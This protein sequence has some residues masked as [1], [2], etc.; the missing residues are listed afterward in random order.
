MSI[1]IDQTIQ[2]VITQLKTTTD[3]EVIKAIVTNAWTKLKKV[4]P[5]ESSFL[6]RV[7][8]PLR[9]AIA[10]AFPERNIEEQ[11]V[12]GYY[13]TNAGKNKEGRWEHLG[14]WYATT[15]EDRWNITGDAARAE[16][17]RNLPTFPEKPVDEQSAPEPVDEQSATEPVDEQS[18]TEPVDEESAPE[19]E[20]TELTPLKLEDMTLEQL[21]LDA[22]T[23]QIVGN[24]LNHS[25]MSLAEFIKQACTV[26]A[27]TVMGKAKQAD[28]DLASVPTEELL[29]VSQEIDGKE[30]RSKY[31]THPK[32][33]EEL[34]RRAIEAIKRHNANAPEKTQ[35]W[36]ITQ[37]AI[38]LLTGSRPATIKEILKKYQ[39]DIENHHRTYELSTLNEIKNEY[40]LDPMINRKGKNRKI[41]SDIDFIG[42]V[43]DGL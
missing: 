6:K 26:Y 8:T 4:V 27:K 3:E 36:A 34:T 38:Q 24:A 22:E 30:V 25:G 10:K 7:R 21:E 43:P 41:E 15:N 12:P 20:Q 1:A 31:F 9:K 5:S 37:T 17:W 16:Y 18:A 2:D 33:A 39:T 23:Q 35:R 32:R 14:L 13:R 11:N 28:D 42:L 19:P 29:N 40:V